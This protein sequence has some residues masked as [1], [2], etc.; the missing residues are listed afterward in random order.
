MRPTVEGTVT[1]SDI[2]VSGEPRDPVPYYIVEELPAGTLI[3][4]VPVDAMLSK[5]HQSSDLT[6]HITASQGRP[7]ET[8]RH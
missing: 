4:S 2:F 5:L 1:S 6:N 3:G 7:T 8:K